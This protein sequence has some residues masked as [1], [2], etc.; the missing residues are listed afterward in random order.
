MT[1]LGIRLETR[2]CAPWPGLVTVSLGGAICRPG[3]DRSAGHASLI[4]AADRA[5][6]AA[7]DGGRD[8]LVMSGQLMTLVAKAAAAQ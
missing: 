8:R 5:L 3:N 4:E 1:S 7:K 6:Y 2:V